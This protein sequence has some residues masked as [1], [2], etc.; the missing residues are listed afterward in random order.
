MPTLSLIIP[1]RGRQGLLSRLLE[2]L[3]DLAEDRS[4]YEVVVVADEDDVPEAPGARVLVGPPGR[5]MGQMTRTGCEAAYGDLVFLLNDDV[6]PRTRGWDRRVIE[7]ARTF[8]DGVALV[9]V[10]DTL[11]R[12]HLCVFPLIPRG[13]RYLVHPGYRRYRI[14]DHVEDVFNILA[15]A[16]E[17]RTVYLEDV[18]FEHHNGID[19]PWGARE[20]HADPVGLAVDAPLFDEL[21]PERLRLALE[22]LA[23]IDAS[24]RA[25]QVA[26]M[27]GSFALRVPGRQ[28]GAERPRPLVARLW[29]RLV[30]A[31]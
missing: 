26:A 24:R 7:A 23:R 5:T 28:V 21:R 25:A 31:R 29:R 15:A 9:H 27:P 3:A 14:D 20:Y 19:M 2:A 17:R 8:A 10:N 22:L 11:M 6:T 12:D 18:V 16:G 1:S 30:G 4:S 13:L